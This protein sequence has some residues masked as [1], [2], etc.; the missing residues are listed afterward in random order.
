MC[1]AYIKH[2]ILYIGVWT[3]EKED[4][5]GQIAWGE[6]GD[7]LGRICCSP[8]LKLLSVSFY[9]GS[10]LEYDQLFV[11]CAIILVVQ[12]S[13]DIGP[14]IDSEFLCKEHSPRYCMVLLSF[15]QEGCGRSF[16]DIK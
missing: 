10:G 7:S 12:P 2:V 6:G 15:Y 4:Q 11:I 14:E 5:E 16:F 3:A 8:F 1:L 9:Q 13:L